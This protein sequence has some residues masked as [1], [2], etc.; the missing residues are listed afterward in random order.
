[1]LSKTF[2]AIESLLA[3]FPVNRGVRRCFSSYNEKRRRKKSFAF[4]SIRDLS[5]PS[6]SAHT[7]IS[8]EG[9][10]KDESLWRGRGEVWRGEGGP[11]FR[12]VPLPPSNLLLS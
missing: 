5:Y 6:S 12:Q 8:D 4:F 11:F 1:P 3:S 10:D 2:G 7:E 9:F